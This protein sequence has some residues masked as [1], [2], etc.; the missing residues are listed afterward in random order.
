MLG[1][2]LRIAGRRERA[3]EPLRRA[4]DAATHAGAR[5]LAERARHELLATGA[6]PRRPALRGVGALT[7]TELRVASLAAQG[8]T[9][10]ELAHTLYVTPKT[11]ETHLA[12][13]YRKLGVAGKGDLAHAMAAG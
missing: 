2:A 7:P 6:R 4:L 5:P 12:A 1:R 3:R 11:I 9:N 13:A 10:R 8:L